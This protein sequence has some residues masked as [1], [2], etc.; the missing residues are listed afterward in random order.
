M[1]GR[2]GATAA[3][4]MGEDSAFES[5][6]AIGL[7][8]GN[9]AI[10]L[11]RR[12]HTSGR[13]RMARKRLCGKCPDGS[14]EIHAPQVF[15]PECTLRGNARRAVRAGGKLFPGFTGA[16]AADKLR[17]TARQFG[18]E[19]ARKLG[20]RSIRRG[21]AGAIVEAGSSFSQLLRAG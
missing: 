19:E 3:R 4:K 1:I 15:C 20:P 6:A 21:A 2:R 16:G 17:S 14:P 10:K 11:N 8:R 18:R 7:E 9:L 13:S 12:V 5:P